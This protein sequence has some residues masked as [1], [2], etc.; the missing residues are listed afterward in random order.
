MHRPAGMRRPAR[1]KIERRLARVR[2]VLLPDDLDPEWVRKMIE[3]TA[4]QSG[5]NERDVQQ[6]TDDLVR[7][8]T[9]DI[10]DLLVAA[11]F[12]ERPHV[13]IGPEENPADLAIRLD[14]PTE[15]D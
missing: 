2:A 7:L 8:L 11:R 9:R 12:C 4:R 6:S 14:A 5:A 13:F 10:P 1:D 3:R 15:T